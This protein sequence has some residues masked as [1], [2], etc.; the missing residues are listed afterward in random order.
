MMLPSFFF[1]LSL[2]FCLYRLLIT[3]NLE[4]YYEIK[5]ISPPYTIFHN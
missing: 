3:E 5:T 4:K 2:Y 1:F